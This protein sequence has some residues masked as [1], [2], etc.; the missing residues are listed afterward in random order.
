MIYAF[1]LLYR[2]CSSSSDIR[3]VISN[4]CTPAKFEKVT[5]DAKA[6]NSITSVFIGNLEDEFIKKF[7]SD[8]TEREKLE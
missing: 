7:R 8:A 3:R 1:H 6:G 2:E 4:K 5:H